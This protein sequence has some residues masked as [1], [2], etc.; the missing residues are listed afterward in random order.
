MAKRLGIYKCEMCGNIV[1]VVTEGPGRLSCCGK[2]MKYFEENTTDAATEKHVPVIE[3]IGNDVKVTVGNVAHPM[4][5]EHFIEWIELFVNDQVLRQD[6]KPGVEPV[7][8]F[9]GVGSEDVTA[10]AYCNLHGLWNS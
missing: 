9:K 10:R 3:K 2:P 1:E 5:D 8:L 7:A 6:L 4:T